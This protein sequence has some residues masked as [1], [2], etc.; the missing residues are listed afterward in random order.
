MSEIAFVSTGDAAEDEN[1]AERYRLHESRMQE[2][3]CPNGC[4]PM[5]WI[6]AHNRDCQKCGFAGFSTKPFDMKAGQ[7]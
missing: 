3:I 2:N 5:N 7:A 6:D 1:L 4:G